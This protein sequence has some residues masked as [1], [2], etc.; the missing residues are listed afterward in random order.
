MLWAI[1][2]L[3]MTTSIGPG[4]FD[5]LTDEQRASALGWLFHKMRPPPEKPKSV[6]GRHREAL[7]KVRGLR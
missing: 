1:A 6:E 2:H 5:A 7:A 3:E 4:G